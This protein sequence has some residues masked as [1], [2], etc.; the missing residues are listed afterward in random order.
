VIGVVTMGMHK[1]DCLEQQLSDTNFSIWKSIVRCLA[2]KKKIRTDGLLTGRPIAV[3]NGQD[4]LLLAELMQNV[5]PH[6]L[7]TI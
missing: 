3:A 6:F 2:H 7:A 4:S 5:P 1:L